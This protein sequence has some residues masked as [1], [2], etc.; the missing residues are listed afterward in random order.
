MLP[1]TGPTPAEPAP[2]S[3][4]FP[5]SGEGGTLARLKVHQT[6][7]AVS[8]VTVRYI[9]SSVRVNISYVIESGAE[10]E[11][12]SS[13]P[14]TAFGSPRCAPLPLI[15]NVPAASSWLKV[16]AAL[17]SCGATGAAHESEPPCQASTQVVSPKILLNDPS[18]PKEYTSS[19]QHARSATTSAPDD[20]HS[21]LPATG[22][23]PAAPSP[24]NF[25]LPTNG[26][27]GFFA[28]LNVHQTPG[29][30]STVTVRLIPSEVSVRIV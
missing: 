24:S 19:N 4:Q 30:V 18:E 13:S 1:A 6:P 22:P 26:D 7:G 28:K 2:S 15:V 21:I 27:T 12:E 14:L 20:H 11:E 8:T 25:Q 16:A 9:P 23:T 5:A 3:F 29:A 10:L 17:P